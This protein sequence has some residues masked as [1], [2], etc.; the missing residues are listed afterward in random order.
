[1]SFDIY[2]G[3]RVMLTVPSR[4]LDVVNGDMGT[5][6]GMKQRLLGDMLTVKLDDGKT[7]SIPLNSYDGVRLG[8]GQTT[9]KGQGTTIEQAFILTGGPMTS[10]QLSY[11]QASRAAD[12]TYLYTDKR[13]AGKEFETLAKQMTI[14]RDKQL[15]HAMSLRAQ[16][17]AAATASRQHEQH[18]EER[19]RQ[20]GKN[21]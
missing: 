11:V 14:D 1:V 21:G 10:K 12:A 13:E 9:H 2:R 16:T 6:I 5:V 15:A 20:R 17:E 3:D 7:V 4:K 18:Q 8:Y 19:M